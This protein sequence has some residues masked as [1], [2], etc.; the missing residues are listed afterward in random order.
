MT[1]RHSS[2]FGKRI[3]YWLIGRMLKEG[4][5]VY[6]P[7]IDD[8]AVDAIVR[9]QDGSIALLQI[10]ARSSD[11]VPGDAGLFAGIPHAARQDYWFIFYSER[12]NTLWI[13]TSQEFLEEADCNKA[14]K[15]IGKHTIW[16]N[17]KRRSKETGEPQE[18]VKARFE[19]YVAMDFSRLQS[20]GI[21]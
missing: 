3:E 14:G 16:F 18:Y 11:C 15:N 17:G 2:G 10:K 20:T 19:K 13:M 4:M 5:D 9:R 1:F 12:L 6:V 8:H 7:L 21:D